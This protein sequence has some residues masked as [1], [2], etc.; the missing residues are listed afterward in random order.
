MA[1]KYILRN[2]ITGYITNEDSSADSAQKHLTAGS[3]D[4]LID[5]RF[6]KFASRGGYSLLGALNTDLTPVRSKFDWVHS[7]NGELNLRMYDDELEVYLETV[8]G[9][10]INAWTRV[11][12]SL[13]TTA[14]V[15]YATWWD[16]AEDID[17]LLFVQGDDNIY[18]WSGAITTLASATAN[19]ITKNGADTWAVARFLTADTRKVTINGTDYT[20]TGGE[21][22]TT[23]TG[24]TPNPSSE[25]ADSVVIQTVITATNTPAANRNNH[26]IFNFENHILVGSD[27]DSENA[28]SKSTDYT[29]YTFSSPRLATEGEL[30]A[31]DGSCR[32][33][34]I[35]NRGLVMFSGEDGLFTADKEQVDV[36]GTLA[37]T[38]N[39]RKLKTG[40][41]QGAFN[42]ETIT[43]IGNGLIYLTNE[44]ALR[45]IETTGQADKPQLKSLSNPIKPDFDAET[46]TNSHA[47][48]HKNRYYLSSPANSRTYILEFQEDANGR[49]RR[50]WHPPQTLPIRAFSIRSGALY[51]HS[52]VVPETYLL[53]NGTT[54][55]IYDGIEVEDKLPINA[56]AITSYRTYGERALLKNHDEFYVEGNISP[57]TDD[58]ELTLRYDFGGY[59]QESL[60]VID[61]T[62]DDILL[63]SLE[64]TSLGQQP[65]GTQPL[66]GSAQE[67]PTLARFR[68]VIEM[69]KED[70]HELQE[71]YESNGVDKAWEI[72][73]AG[74]NIKISPNKNTINRQ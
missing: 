49:L 20:Y 64:A 21:G 72:L 3:H 19:T 73:S 11:M 48:W 34:G 61:G 2:E 50:F 1:E 14:I 36:G 9:V 59:T 66:G 13:S 25:A 17:L 27:D 57:A 74:G 7:K 29:D 56:K 63:E 65:L 47:I 46:W 40:V 12:D 32:G 45:M 18:E 28:V 53:F 41:K 62:N 4:V 54:D 44:S 42:Q 24:V 37:E 8:D 60:F 22:T 52:N 55:R 51:G 26:Y 71:I 31:L 33:F 69:P 6:G 38:W 30:F 5:P 58:L 39:V 67:P 10:E 70:Y 15:R 68:T 35:V 23:L 43:P 16:T